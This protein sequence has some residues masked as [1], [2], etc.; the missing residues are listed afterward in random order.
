MSKKV[1]VAILRARHDPTIP[2]IND[3]ACISMLMTNATHH[4]LLNYWSYNTYNYL[5]F[6]D[7]ALFPWVDIN[8]SSNDVTRETQAAKAY[9]ATKAIPNNNVDYFDVYFIITYPGRMTIANPKA[10]QP[11]EPPTIVLDFDSGFAGSI[12]NN[13]NA[14]AIPVM[15]TDHTIMCHEMGHVLGF[16]DSYGVLNN[17]IEWD[18]RPPYD[19]GYIYGDPYDI[20]S[21]S[22]FGNHNLDP[23]KPKYYSSPVFPGASHGQWPV[24][25]TINMGPAPARAH[26]HL[27]E[28]AAIPANKIRDIQT[29]LFNNRQRLRLYA[30][31]SN[32]SPHLIIVRA[33]NEDSAGRNRCYIEYRENKGWDKGLDIYGSDLARRGVVVHTLA[34]ATNN[35]VRC[36]YRGNIEVP[37][38]IDSDLKVSGTPLVIRVVNADVNE[39]YVD[40]EISSI[41]ERGIEITVTRKD[42]EVTITNAHEMS[43]PCGDKIMYGTLILQSKYFYMPVSYGYGGEGSP[44][45]TPPIIKWKVYGETINGSGSI[46]IVTS[47][48][49]VY[50]SIDPVTQ[51]LSLSSNPAERYSLSVEATVTEPNGSNPTS[52]TTVFDPPGW[53][54]GFSNADQI[55]L[56]KCLDKYLHYVKMRRHD[57][58]IPSG[59]DPYRINLTDRINKARLIEVVNHA[60]RSNPSAAIA[61]NVLAVMRYGV[62]E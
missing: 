27:W 50:Y 11:N 26:V 6:I 57:F 61:L 42:D 36:W 48:Y 24:T 40:V 47:A 51:E 5:D 62:S 8:I 17:G 43:T 29:P 19:E 56:A 23:A 20:M 2:Y 30:A 12:L 1:K 14:C 52:A 28:P 37:V 32:K 54:E 33:V 39:G 44:I 55:K 10:G 58:L 35:G 34:D 3:A 9:T 53:H 15:T 45:E 16:E 49:P 41:Q 7:S 4:G 59:P 46:S 60:K 38:E 22:T 18:L 25:P 13:K 21:A 31:S